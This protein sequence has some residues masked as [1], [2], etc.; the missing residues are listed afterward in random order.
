M[1]LTHLDLLVH[2]WAQSTVGIEISVRRPRNGGC[3]L[4][5]GDQKRDGG[6]GGVAAFRREGA[7]RT[8]DFWEGRG[9]LSYLQRKKVSD[10][11]EE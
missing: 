3:Q 7:Q 5:D 1:T 6:G 10:L 11:L 8:L 4:S 2:H 9:N